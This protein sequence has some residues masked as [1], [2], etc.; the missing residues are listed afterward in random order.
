MKRRTSNMI[1]SVLSVSALGI[2]ALPIFAQAV[3]Q[4]TTIEVNTVQ[5]FLNEYLSI[6][7]EWIDVYG[8]VNVTYTPIT[9]VDDSNYGIVLLAKGFYDS[10][11]AN[12]TF[13]ADG[14]FYVPK[15]KEEMDKD[16]ALKAKID[17]YFFLDNY[18]FR[19]VDDAVIK[20]QEI[21]AAEE[22]ERQQQEE[23]L[24][25][26]EEQQEEETKKDFNFISDSN[27]NSPQLGVESEG[28][29]EVETESV[30]SL[31]EVDKKEIVKVNEGAT[32]AIEA[33][34]SNSL[35]EMAKPV[36][37]VEEEKVE[38]ESSDALAAPVVEEAEMEI[39][40][41]QPAL[42]HVEEVELTI[43]EAAV[44]VVDTPTILMEN[45]PSKDAQD[46]VGTYLTS[47]QG[48]IYAQANQVNYQT[49]LNSLSAW[50]KL[51]QTD[52]DQVNS[53][54]QNKVGKTYQTLLQEAQT[55]KSG[56][57]PI[58]PG[59][60]TGVE[61]NAGLYATL[62]GVSAVVFGFITRKKEIL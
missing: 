41:D 61:N 49:I 25:Q 39:E 57:I 50:N 1:A 47:S 23:L 5:D 10:L 51:S 28:G 21:I 48:I 24:K 58:N 13:V 6:K 62:C 22:L 59:V 12:V 27:E 38:L 54:L 44:M 4:E 56:G 34:N 16:L 11:S 46:F 9:Y 37:E 33:G 20:N 53:I 15:T 8:N 32:L 35:L 7:T 29:T 36:I 2:Q 55:I 43:E 31:D 3:V 30:G 19:L 14:Q 45:S 60:Q 26:T 18:F 40:I 42:V 52:K 17:E